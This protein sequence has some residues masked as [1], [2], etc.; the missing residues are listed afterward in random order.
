[1][2]DHDRAAMTQITDDM[3]KI[4][5]ENNSLSRKAMRLTDFSLEATGTTP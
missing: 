4:T 2:V 1:M 5:M 3:K